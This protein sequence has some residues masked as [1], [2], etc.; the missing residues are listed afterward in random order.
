MRQQNSNFYDKSYCIRNVIIPSRFF[1]APIN[2]GYSQ[3]GQP[4]EKLI[5]FHNKRS[6]KAIGISYVGNVAIN[7]EYVT[8]IKTLFFDKETLMWNN[9]VSAISN[10]GSLPGLQLGCRSSQLLPLRQWENNNPQKC[11]TYLTNEIYSYSKEFIYDIIEKFIQNAIIAWGLGFKVIQIHAAHGYLLSLLLSQTI[12]N[13]DDEFGQNKILPIQLIVNG[14]RE[15]IPDVILDVRISLLEGINDESSE[16]DYKYKLIKNIVDLDLDIISISNGIYDINKKL[17]YPPKE[18]GNGAF[19]SKVYPF[20]S[21]YKSKLWN[22]CGNIWDIGMLDPTLPENLT[23]SIGRSLIA[24]PE[25]VE[26]YISGAEKEIMK[27][28]R[29]ESCHYYSAGKKDLTCTIGDVAG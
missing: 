10:N 14:I 5:E 21:A 27:C 24:D 8:N 22:V 26:K 6:G 29:C 16:L 13:R 7:K 25:F 2:T 4:T 9:L 18:W 28:I 17:I 3:G 20:A 15:I 11:V 12:N 23:F 19:I 1:F